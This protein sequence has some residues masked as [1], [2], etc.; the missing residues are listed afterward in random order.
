MPFEN[1]LSAQAAGVVEADPHD[2]LVGAGPAIGGGHAGQPAAEIEQLADREVVVEV[3]LLGQEAH[4][5]AGG[6]ARH[7]RAEDLG[8]AAGDRAQPHQAADRRG[9]AGAVGAEEAEHLAAG[10]GERHARSASTRGGGTACGRS[11]PGR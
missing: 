9:L 11:W 6:P 10:D 8:L 3:R 4:A 5:L 7:R 2:Q 1:F